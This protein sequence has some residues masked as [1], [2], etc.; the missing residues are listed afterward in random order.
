[1]KK[2][3]LLDT[4]ICIYLLKKQYRIAEQLIKIGRENC[5]ISDITLAELYYGASRSGQKEKK[6]EGVRFVE[7]YFTVLPIHDVLE[8]FGDSKAFLKSNGLLIDDFDLLIGATAVV[9]NLI[10][11]TENVKHL[12]RIPDIRIENWIKKE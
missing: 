12:S 11:V 3:Y 8:K 1:M 7:E 10:M 2:Q 5:F 9:Y 6:M 4:N